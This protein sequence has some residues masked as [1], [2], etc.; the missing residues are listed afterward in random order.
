MLVAAAQPCCHLLLEALP[1]H[2]APPCQGPDGSYGLSLSNTSVLAASTLVVLTVAKMPFSDNYEETYYSQDLE[3]TQND[4]VTVMSGGRERASWRA[5][6]CA[7]GS[8]SVF[9]VVEGYVRG[10]PCGKELAGCEVAAPGSG[11]LGGE[12]HSQ[13]R[14][15]PEVKTP[16]TWPGG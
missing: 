15:W 2:Q 10:R 3:M 14:A 6:A 7:Q 4:A 1:A 8:A 13:A 9:P 16:F 5:R 11:C 12:S